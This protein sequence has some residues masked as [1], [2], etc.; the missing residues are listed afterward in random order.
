MNYN[1]EKLTTIAGCDEFVNECGVE[2]TALMNKKNILIARLTEDDGQSDM[3]TRADFLGLR[4]ASV[5]AL[6]AQNPPEE[7]FHK[8]QIELGKLIKERGTLEQKIDSI[9]KNWQIETMFEIN[10]CD[11]DHA[12]RDALIVEIN[13]HKATLAA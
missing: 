5:D 3:Q 2:K 9:G 10:K 12:L 1:F 13:A 11:S 7:E 4:I 6:I 8:L